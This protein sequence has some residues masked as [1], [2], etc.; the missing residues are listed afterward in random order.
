MKDLMKGVSGML[1]ATVE[2]KK[3]GECKKGTH[4][5]TSRKI[6]ANLRFTWV[7]R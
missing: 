5:S 1:I 6:G 2:K 4:R 7:K 3:R